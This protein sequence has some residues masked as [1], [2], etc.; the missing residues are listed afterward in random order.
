MLTRRSALGV[1]TGLVAVRA[2]HAQSFPSPPITIVVPYPAGG[3]VDVTARLIA[4]S[5]ARPLG[6][7]M[8]GDSRGGGAAVIANVAVQPAEPDGHG[9]ILGTNQTPAP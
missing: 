7:A 3:P 2:A 8:R 6:D 5:I 9:P 4:Q 1:M